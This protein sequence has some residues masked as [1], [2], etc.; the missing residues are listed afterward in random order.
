MAQCPHCANRLFFRPLLE[1]AYSC[2][3]AFQETVKDISIRSGVSPAIARHWGK[4]VLCEKFQQGKSIC[5]V[6]EEQP[7]S[8]PSIR[9]EGEKQ[10]LKRIS[11][12][13]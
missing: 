6:S 8:V 7:F 5:E 11:L 10:L 9:L 4:D 12:L 2:C 3:A 13:D 1:E